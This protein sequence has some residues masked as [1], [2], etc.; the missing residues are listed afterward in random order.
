[1]V[2]VLRLERAFQ[3]AADMHSTL[4]EPGGRGVRSAVI[5]QPVDTGKAV[6]RLHINVLGSAAELERDIIPDRFME[7]LRKVQR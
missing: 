6:G 5:T 2:A 4:S 3:S 1:M 7:R